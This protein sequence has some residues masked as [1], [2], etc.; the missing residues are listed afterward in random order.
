M[1]G[2]IAVESAADVGSAALAWSGFLQQLAAFQQGKASTDDLVLAG[3]AF[4]ASAQQVLHSS[5]LGTA[6]GQSVGF[7]TSLA[8]LQSDIQAYNTASDADDTAGMNEAVAGLVSDAAGVG[9]GL[10]GAIG[11]Y[12]ALIGEKGLVE[13]AANLN[14]ASVAVAAV[15]TAVGTAYSAANWLANY[16]ND[17]SNALLNGAVQ[18]SIEMWQLDISG[19]SGNVELMMAGQ[20]GDSF[21]QTP[22]GGSGFQYTESGT[23]PGSV[24]LAENGASDVEYASGTDIVTDIT[25]FQVVL[26]TANNIEIDGSRNLIT[27]QGGSSTAT[28]GGEE[29]SVQ[30]QSSA[31][32]STLTFEGDG[33]ATNTLDL[34]DATSTS[35]HLGDAAATGLNITSEGN[36]SVSV[37]AV[38]TGA[39]ISATTSGILA[40]TATGMT[41]NLEA[42]QFQLAG[43]GDTVNLSAGVSVTVNAGS[44]DVI[45]STK[46]GKSFSLSTGPFGIF[47][48]DAPI[49]STGTGE[50]LESSGNY[51]SDPVTFT[52]NADGSMTIETSTYG[53]Y[54]TTKMDVNPDGQPVDSYL[55]ENGAL[56]SYSIYA[57]TNGTLSGR[58]DYDAAGDLL[59]SSVLNPD[60]SMASAI[61]YDSAGVVTGEAW[62]TATGETQVNL[63]GGIV[64]GTMVIA[65]D[66]PLTGV[67]DYDAFGNEEVEESINTQSNAAVIWSFNGGA[68]N[69]SEEETEGVV[70]PGVEALTQ[71]TLF[72][73]DTGQVTQSII[74]SGFNTSGIAST[75]EVLTSN[76]G[77][78]FA[79]ADTY[80]AQTGQLIGSATYDSG[81][82]EITGYT[83]SVTPSA[84][85]ATGGYLDQ[86]ASIRMGTTGTSGNDM[87]YGTLGADLFDG[88]GGNDVEV[89]DG[90][91]DTYVLQP[92]Y[93]SLTIVNGIS[94]SNTAAGDLSIQYANPNDIWLQRVGNNLQVDLMGSTTEAT[95]QNW[96]SNTYSQLGEITVSGGS[97]GNL[98]VDAQINQLVQA[99]AT[100][101][102][103]NPGFDPTSA[104]NPVITDPTVL[105]AVNTAWH[106]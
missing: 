13:I 98:T 10:A 100:F 95:I 101:S 89:G 76:G 2:I 49:I 11:T 77:Q 56:N 72:N 33:T 21:T 67:T 40:L 55:Y 99:M 65:Y 94:S 4:V 106:Q 80:N 28:I 15:A 66:G 24:Q 69:A 68:A 104:S 50:I 8:A 84:A 27:V 30:V 63:S 18:Q 20:S 3:A 91:S 23:Q 7:V 97:A 36:S 37:D 1:S 90:G 42:G 17:L 85:V 83:G 46:T 59:E 44:N 93:G 70:S 48:L 6:L 102:G 5:T 79:D 22:L 74:Y 73:S 45:T 32:G 54:V 64:V 62:A 87:L 29:N 52:G 35:V 9:G 34:Q 75:K 78:Y 88:K 39:S 26:N 86:G 103:N 53:G 14:A 43:S 105:A 82:G 58:N 57:D 92:G 60:G 71:D 41:L 16:L 19:D 12:G 38:A 25:G 31:S 47:K 81:T 61:S 96:F 51:A